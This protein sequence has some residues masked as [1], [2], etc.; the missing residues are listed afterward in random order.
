VKI[1]RISTYKRHSAKDFEET[2]TGDNEFNFFSVISV[3]KILREF[4]AKGTRHKCNTGGGMK[5][6]NL[7]KYVLV[8]IKRKVKTSD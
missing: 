6:F 5:L 4:E 1:S 7:G 2:K 8:L 3:P